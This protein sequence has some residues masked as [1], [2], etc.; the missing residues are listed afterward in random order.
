MSL[1][2]AI[3]HGKEHRKEYTKAKSRAKS[4]RN[5][6]SCPWCQGNRHHKNDKR[7]QALV[8][9]ETIHEKED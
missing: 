3:E 7:R 5:H 4:H 8:D 6:G 2:K 1:T 9:R